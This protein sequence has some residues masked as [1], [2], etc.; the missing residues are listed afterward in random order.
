GTD[1][2]GHFGDRRDFAT[3]DAVR[4]VL[5]QVGLAILDGAEGTSFEVRTPGEDI[6]D[7]VLDAALGIRRD[8]RARSD[9]ATSDAIRD[10]LA[11]AGVKVLD[12]AEGSRWELG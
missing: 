6:L 4:D 3:A 1:G 2:V 8:A 5:E 10:R 12:S 9:Y 11:E 7:R